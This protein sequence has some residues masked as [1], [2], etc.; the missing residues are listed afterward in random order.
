MTATL[1][2]SVMPDY[3]PAVCTCTNEYIH[4]KS[5]GTKKAPYYL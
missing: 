5:K 4:E 2:H 1:F 3:G